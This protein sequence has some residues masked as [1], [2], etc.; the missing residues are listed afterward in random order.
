MGRPGQ[1]IERVYSHPQALAQCGSWLDA[2]LPDAERVE[3]SSTS[4]AVG[5]ALSDPTGA[6]IAYAARGNLQILERD[7]GPAGNHTRFFVVTRTFP[8]A[9]GHD[10]SLVSF[11]A[12]HKPGA[13]YHCLEPFATDGINLLRL[14]HRPSASRDWTYDFVAEVE[15]H[16][17]TPKLAHALES[18]RRYATEVRILGAWPTEGS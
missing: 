4:E 6:A 5:V 14:E 13:L 1:R 15:G 18:L 11:Q 7:I 3:S 2:H 8:P 16:P 10:R 17:T 9:S 12:P